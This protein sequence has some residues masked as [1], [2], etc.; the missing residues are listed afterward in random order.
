MTD[1]CTLP[2]ELTI[3]TV[4]ELAPQCRAWLDA[5]ADAAHSSLRVQA[6][7][8]AEVDAAGVQLLLSLANT[9]Q[10][11]DRQLQLLEP[12]A[13]LSAACQALG[14]ASLLGAHADHGG[15]A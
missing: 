12:S 8:V 6:Q 3:Y 5:H 14:A 9:L 1:A 15:K 7:A 11:R 13:T 2:P 4:G 10:A